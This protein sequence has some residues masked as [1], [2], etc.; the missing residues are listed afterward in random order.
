MSAALEFRA[1]VKRYGRRRALDGLDLAVPAGSI[2]GLVGSNGAGKTTAFGLAAGLLRP[3]GGA[4]DVLGLGPYDPARHAGRLSLLPQDALLPAE[5]PA[6][7]LLVY[8][9]RLQGLDAAGAAREAAALLE[10]VHL[11]DRARSPAGTLSHGMRRR[12]TIAQA[13]LGEPDLILLDEPLSG[14][15][16]REAA[17]IRGLLA[18]L[19]GRRT[20]VISSHNLAELERMCDH[21]IMI[22]LGRAVRQGPMER[23]TGRLHVLRYELAAGPAPVDRLRLA[24]PD[25]VFTEAEGGRVLWCRYDETSRD[26]AAIN[27][28][29]LA[30][31]LESGAGILAVAQGSGLEQAYLEHAAAR[32][33]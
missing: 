29:V 13:L 5:A 32:G 17:G 24:L 16:P 15:D 6:L 19:R 1:V 22:E 8:Y 27:R 11:A 7:D 23:M 14:L 21:V 2:C 33:T 12:I 26:P 25:A 30:A 28:V 31:L 18:G 10:R 9:A 3:D 20:V 4:I